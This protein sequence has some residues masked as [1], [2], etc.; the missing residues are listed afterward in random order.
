M[1]MYIVDRSYIYSSENRP[2]FSG[3]ENDEL[4]TMCN[5]IF[6]ARIVKMLNDWAGLHWFPETSEIGAEGGSN[7]DPEEIRE[8][9]ENTRDQ[10][11]DEIIGMDEDELRA[12]YMEL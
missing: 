6:T 11:A 9:F 7:I 4:E 1:A 12:A 8:W 3:W 2:D 10:I 5:D